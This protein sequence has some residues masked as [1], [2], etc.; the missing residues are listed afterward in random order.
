[1]NRESISIHDLTTL[2]QLAL[3]ER[4]GH[5]V[6]QFPSLTADET[7]RWQKILNA[8][9]SNCGCTTGQIFVLALFIP[10][11]I[12]IVLRFTYSIGWSWRWEVA[13]GL[14]VL[15]GS[16]TLG[17]TVGL[18]LARKRLRKSIGDLIKLIKTRTDSHEGECC[19]GL[20]RVSD[21]NM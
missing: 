12:S 9:Y 20:R 18:K 10:Y 4:R 21:Q 5:I 2:R 3:K 16:A 11:L 17:K 6:L 1:M 7:V 8:H 19:H 14:G 13:V 15:L